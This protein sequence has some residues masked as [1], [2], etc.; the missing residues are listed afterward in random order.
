VAAA[1]AWPRL[2]R[3]RGCGRRRRY[4]Q[5][6]CCDARCPGGPCGTWPFAPLSSASRTGWRRRASA[7]PVGSSS[8]GPP[9]WQSRGPFCGIHRHAGEIQPLG[10]FFA[11]MIRRL[12]VCPQLSFQLARVC[13]VP[14][15]S[16]KS[17]AGFRPADC[18][19]QRCTLRACAA[20]QTMAATE[21]LRQLMSSGVLSCFPPHLKMIDPGVV[22]NDRASHLTS[23][24]YQMALAAHRPHAVYDLRQSPSDLAPE[25]RSFMARP[26][27]RLGRRASRSRR[28]AAPTSGASSMF[29]ETRIARSTGHGSRTNS[30]AWSLLRLRTNRRTTRP[31]ELSKAWMTANR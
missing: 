25:M 4:G 8:P 23:V 2:W 11:P 7:L 16:E 1:V 12:A 22:A 17:A 24:Q 29:P 18:P 9:D 28:S 15:G 30:A 31:G 20:R 10:P 6:A 13:R 26:I 5:A 27:R 14:D 19:P 3:G 21:A